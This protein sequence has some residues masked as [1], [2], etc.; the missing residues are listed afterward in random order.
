MEISSNGSSPSSD[1]DDIS[2]EDLPLEFHFAQ[3]EPEGTRT[4]SLFYDATNT[5][6]RNFIV[7][8]LEKCGVERD[9][10]CG[11]PCN[12]AEHAEI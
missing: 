7:R 1:T 12:P 6:A 11:V 5:F 10:N 9:G 3:L 4:D 8:A 2:E